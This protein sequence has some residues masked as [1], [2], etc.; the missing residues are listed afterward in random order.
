MEGTVGE[1]LELT[2]RA[3]EEA[4]RFYEELA[5]RFAHAPQVAAFWQVMAEDEKDHIRLV[6]L[7]RSC[8]APEQ[9]AEPADPVMFHKAQDALRFSARAA[10]ERIH[11]LN[12]AYEAASDLEYGEVNVVFQFIVLH[13]LDDKIRE[14]LVEDYTERHLRRLRL[15]GNIGGLEWREGILA[16]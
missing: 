16:Q 2:L 6:E 12:D 1:L 5:Q 7:A 14:Q 8:L 3:E 15:L 4:L 9:L 13:Y 11:N 10:L